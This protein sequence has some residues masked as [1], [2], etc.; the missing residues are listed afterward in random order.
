MTMDG[1]THDVGKW[2]LLIA[3]PP[4]T[5]LSNAATRSFSL[6]VS[7]AEKV[8]ARWEERVKA[9]IFFMQFMLADVPKIAVENPVGIM[10]KAYRKADQIIHPYYFAESE[11]DTENYHTKRTC[12]WL[13]NL[14]PL[15]R[16]TTFHRQSLCTSQMGKSTR[17]SAGAKEYAERQTAKRAGQKPEAKQRRALQKQW[18]NSGG[19][20]MGEK[21][22]HLTLYGDP[23]TKKN[24][25]RILKSRS[26][27][28]FVAPSKAYVDYE[29]D[30]LRQI[31][32]PRSPISARVNV[33]CVYYMKTTRRVDLANLIEATTDILVKAHVLE[34]DNS[35]IV[36][37]HDGSR[38][39]L[40][41]K[42]PRV[43]IEIEEMEE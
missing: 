34:D 16:K 23:R 24:S 25:A 10:N 12:L 8:V 30:C 15:E 37:A 17:K 18:L 43:E 39:E 1:V 28:R 4:C 32:R 14:P 9:A 40:D 19:K 5:Y 35:K 20:Q 2:D 33:R 36:A 31:K 11:E 22:I 21:R 26:G 6:R 41:R 3:H 38:V 7:P 27:G 29:T 13:K 42:Q